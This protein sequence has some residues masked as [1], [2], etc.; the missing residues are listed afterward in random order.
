MSLT[1][2]LKLKM[3]EE[4]DRVAEKIE[5][6]M[7]DAVAPHSASGDALAAIHIEYIDEYT[8]FVGGTDGTGTGKTGTDHLKLLNDGNGTGGIPKN[9]KPK[10]PMPLTYGYRNEPPRG[11]AM[12][13]KNY[14]GIHF[15]EEIANRHR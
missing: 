6:E 3:Q 7:Q 13:V 2:M 1:E 10:R 5:A 12:H 11:Y 4:L 15:V 8:R 14:A 9:G